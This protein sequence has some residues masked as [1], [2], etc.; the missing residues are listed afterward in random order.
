M[1][2]KTGGQAALQRER[3][4]LPPATPEQPVNG[5]AVKNVHHDGF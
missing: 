1:M 5:N 2:E 3:Q 4:R